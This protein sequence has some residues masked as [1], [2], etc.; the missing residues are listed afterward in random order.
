MPEDGFY[1]DLFSEGFEA[2]INYS[3]PKCKGYFPKGKGVS[4]VCGFL[5]C[6]EEC[7]NEADE[8]GRKKS[9]FYL[10]EGKII[11]IVNGEERIVQDAKTPSQS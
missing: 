4:G 2:C 8:R 11:E 5:Y 1:M 10:R 6:C 7:K 3:N 9:A